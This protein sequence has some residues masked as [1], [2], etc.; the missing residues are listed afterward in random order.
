MVIVGGAVVLAAGAAGAAIKLSAD[1]AQQ[2]E[3]YTGLPPADLEDDDLTEAMNEL[4]IQGQ[5]VT[6][7]DQAALSGE[8]PA[9]APA[10]ASPPPAAPATGDPSYINELEKLADLR[11]R[12]I[13]TDED[14]EAKKKELLGL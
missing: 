2:I 12:G 10:P 9:A 6:A 14:F 13:I 11:D 8:A 4:G 1:D 5:P 3:E 7:E